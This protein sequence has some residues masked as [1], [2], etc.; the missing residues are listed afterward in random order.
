MNF[1]LIHLLAINYLP[2]QLRFGG[3]NDHLE[4]GSVFKISKL[5]LIEMNLHRF[6]LIYQLSRRYGA[7]LSLLK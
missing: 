7:S 3:L 5:M 1:A 4:I 6:V 2:F